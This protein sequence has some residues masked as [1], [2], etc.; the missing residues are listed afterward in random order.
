[1][2]K[3][4]VMDESRGSCRV[5]HNRYFGKNKYLFTFIFFSSAGLLLEDQDYISQHVQV[6]T[7]MQ[8]QTMN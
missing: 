4:L 5:E 6:R 8:E 3:C 1:M 7:Q 2:M